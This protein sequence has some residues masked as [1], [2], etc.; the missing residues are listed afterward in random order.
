MPLGAERPF[1][2]GG[3]AHARLPRAADMRLLRDGE[4]IAQ[5]H[6]DELHHP[7]E[8]HGVHRLEVSLGKRPWI[9]SNPLYFRA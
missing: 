9:V 5:T 8:L 4:V 1:E 7:I 6:S 2:P 3:T